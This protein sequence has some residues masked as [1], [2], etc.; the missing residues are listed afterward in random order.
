VLL[1]G[2]GSRPSLPETL[3]WLRACAHG[4]AASDDTRPRKRGGLIAQLPMPTW[5]VLIDQKMWL[6]IRRGQAAATVV[7]GLGSLRMRAGT[8]VAR[9][10]D[11]LPVGLFVVTVGS[12]KGGLHM[13]AFRLDR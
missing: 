10:G 9:L 6:Q 12:P 1:C 7:Y 5:R 13:D 8:S 2:V 3:L 4:L 11:L